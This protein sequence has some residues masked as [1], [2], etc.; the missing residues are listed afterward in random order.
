MTFKQAET[1]Q[2]FPSSPPCKV[3]RRPSRGKK[4]DWWYISQVERGF[5]LCPNVLLHYIIYMLLLWHQ[6]SL[7]TQAFLILHTALI[8]TGSSQRFFSLFDQGTGCHLNSLPSK[9]DSYRISCRKGR[10]D[11]RKQN[12]GPS[13]GELSSATTRLQRSSPLR[14]CCW[15][16]AA[17]LKLHQCNWPAATFPFQSKMRENFF[18]VLSICK[19][20]TALLCRSLNALCCS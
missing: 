19:P 9:H 1:W 3:K 2:K 17:A 12:P 5:I 14:L 20:V 18:L 8:R 6:S 13:S 10:L 11:S 16:W 7:T 15:L 4:F